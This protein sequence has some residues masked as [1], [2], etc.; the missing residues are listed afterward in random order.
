MVMNLT[1]NL[2]NTLLV[3]LT[4]GCSSALVLKILSCIT[5]KRCRDVSGTNTCLHSQSQSKV[6]RIEVLA[7][8]LYTFPCFLFG[9]HATIYTQ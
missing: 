4:K 1:L 3:L 8:H 9:L 5:L 6:M 2:I 7:C